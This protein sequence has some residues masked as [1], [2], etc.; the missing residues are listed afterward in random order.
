MVV[1]AIPAWTSNRL[2][3][4]MLTAK[5]YSLSDRIL[6]APRSTLWASAA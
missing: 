4:L 3:R 2:K 6:A 1:D 5:R